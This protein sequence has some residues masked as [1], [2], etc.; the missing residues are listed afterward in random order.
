M[1]PVR[2]SVSNFMPYRENV[3]PLS[4]AGVH[5]ASIC[6]D[7]GSGKSSLIDAM[8]WALWGKTRARS[9]DDLIY[10]GETTMQ[11]E[12]DF[13]VGQQT[14]RVIRK[15]ARPKS[16]RASGQSSLDLLIAN[17]GAF[18]LI[19]GDKIADTQKKIVD[20]L[21][22]DYETFINSAFLR[23]G[24]ADQF[25]VARPAERKEVLTN[26][27][28]LSTYDRLEEQAK[29]LADNRE[30]EKAQ[31]ESAIKEIDAELCNQPAY[32][33]ELEQAQSRLADMEKVI[34]EAEA[35]MGRLRQQHEV[36]RTRQE[37]LAQLDKQVAQLTKDMGRWTE[38]ARQHLL[39]IDE[40]EQ[41][42]A[43]RAAI[44]EG[45]ASFAAAKKENEDLNQRLRLIT[46]L[47]DREHQLDLAIEQAGKPLLK[48]HTL[49]ESKIAELQAKREKAVRIRT[50]RAQV[51]SELAR[52]SQ[53]EEEL[54][55]ARQ[56]SQRGLA[57]LH[58]LESDKSRAEHEIIEI[59]EKLGLLS[60]QVGA[61]CPLCESELTPEHLDLIKEKYSAEGKS[62]S[63]AVDSMRN[64]IDRNKARVIKL[65]GEI[66]QTEAKLN[67][68]RSSLHARIGVLDREAAEADEAAKLREIQQT[69]LNEIEERLAKKD[70]ALVE[71][72]A[73]RQLETQI[74]ATEYDA[75]HHEQVR[76]NL[77]ELEYYEASK[78]KLEEAESLV[79]GEKK[80]ASDA[81]QAAL[82]LAADLDSANRRR[83]EA[84]AEL[85]ELPS[86]VSD[87]N[88]LEAEYRALGEQ[89]KLAT[90][91]VGSAKEKLSRCALFEVSKR[92]KEKKLADAMKEEEV[93]RELAEA[94]GKK[95]LQA[96]LIEMALPEIEAEANRLLSRM[97]D[98]RM[99]VKFE[100]QRE[101]RKGDVLETLDINIADE[102]GT[103][104]Y[105][106]FSGGEAF[107][108]NF[109]IRIA[110][111][112]LLA[113][114]AG[115]PLPTLIIDEG[116]GTQDATG[117]EKIREAIGA[118]QDDFEKILV[119]TH[120]EDFRD[121]FPTRIDIVKMPEGSTIEVN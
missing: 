76:R 91:S 65:E 99:H 112:K 100:T 86:V 73:R 32:L 81:D 80:T 50:D 21:H 101:T 52:L 78:R 87:V 46:V 38:Q 29:E 33:H 36:L 69:K 120:I 83:T 62:K 107:R 18:K 68:E 12:F 40:Y 118:I 25:T 97:T 35:R 53:S 93:Y 71:Q 13:S 70:Y 48:E 17:D 51:E 60:T 28:G 111:S 49:A 54:T 7:N 42:L 119:I 121:A 90:E 4:F 59:D 45:Y 19:S 94:F 30:N 72:E 85:E 116:F 16:R 104:S 108:I 98:N 92:D 103:R 23:Q 41:L 55:R 115:A 44:E 106:M 63:V 5:T 39:R 3:P 64:E 66:S 34:A 24:H 57:E 2:L 27:I 61:K 9:D 31:L 47:R 113:R 109:A 95:G 8:T 14:Y 1:I 6:G 74:S 20:T 82:E 11:V 88:N 102:L 75:S 79:V 43:K 58:R 67:H 114:R 84:A 77:T 26:I 96:L 89:Q 56:D 110:L 15:H 10:Q 105:E 22:M 117:M 37:Q